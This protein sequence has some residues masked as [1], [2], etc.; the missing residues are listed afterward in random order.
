MSIDNPV[1]NLEC[2]SNKCAPNFTPSIYQSVCKKATDKKYSYHFG[3]SQCCFECVAFRMPL[4]LVTRNHILSHASLELPVGRC[5]KTAGFLSLLGLVGCKTLVS[6]PHTSLVHLHP[7]VP[8]VV[9][10][11]PLY[12]P[13]TRSLQARAFVVGVVLFAAA[14]RSLGKSLLQER[15]AITHILYIQQC[16]L[17][18]P[19]SIKATCQTWTGRN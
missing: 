15:S 16:M 18:I 13:R 9:T 3:S 2:T 19:C 14:K 17:R 8:A 10:L 6:Q 12:M 5:V 1:Q 7:A 4:V 11:A